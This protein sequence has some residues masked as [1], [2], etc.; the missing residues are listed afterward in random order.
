MMCDRTLTQPEKLP[1]SSA[2]S[3]F[4]APRRVASHRFVS[5]H[6]DGIASAG[7]FFDEKRTVKLTYLKFNVGTKRF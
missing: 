6:R 2:S 5:P 7:Y 1:D 3:H 4:V